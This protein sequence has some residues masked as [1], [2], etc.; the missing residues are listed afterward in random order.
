MH[1]CVCVCLLYTHTIFNYPHA[2][3]LFLT[4][5]FLHVHKL[6]KLFLVK[7]DPWIISAYPPSCSLPST[8]E[9][10]IEMLVSFNQQLSDFQSEQDFAIA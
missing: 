2:R 4:Y 7:F 1:V 8:I 6:F 10:T 3:V 5:H 9:E